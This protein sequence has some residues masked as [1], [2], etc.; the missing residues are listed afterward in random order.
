MALKVDYVVKETGTN[1]RRNITLTLATLIT[2]GVSL[3]LSGAALLIRAGVDNAT[4]QWKGGIEFIVFM[5]PDASQGQID[6]VR[7]DLKNSPAIKSFKYLD[8]DA[9]FEEFK[10]L[11]SD[12]PE[13]YENVTADILPTSFKVVPVD[14]SNENVSA[15]KQQF[16]KK[17]GVAQVVAA[18]EI[19]KSF[20]R[21]SSVVAKVVLVAAI[22]LGLAAIVLITNTIRMAMFARRREIEVMKLVGATNW[23]IR[24]P[25]MLEGL[26]QG[27]VGGLVGVGGVYVVAWLLRNKVASAPG[28]ELFRSFVVHGSDVF[29]A[30]I[31]VLVVGCVVGVIGSGWAV[32]RFLDV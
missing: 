32:T 25:F 8:H 23:F 20:E 22:C 24:V 30:N 10:K 2:V 15:L 6:A 13:F 29:L 26:V 5:K 11:F 4:I 27:V 18:L 21:M 14:P 7:S 16:E 12:Q 31:L 9:A 17:A 3:A 19:I 1:L 28:L